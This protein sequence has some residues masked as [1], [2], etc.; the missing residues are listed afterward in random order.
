MSIRRY[1]LH[2]AYSE[3]PSLHTG[4]QQQGNTAHLGRP[5]VDRLAALRFPIPTWAVS[6][7]GSFSSSHTQVSRIPSCGRALVTVTHQ[8]TNHQQIKLESRSYPILPWIRQNCR[9]AAGQKDAASILPLPTF[10]CAAVVYGYLSRIPP[11]HRI[12]T[13]LEP[14]SPFGPWLENVSIGTLI[15]DHLGERPPPESPLR[16]GLYLRLYP[17]ATRPS[18][19]QTQ[20]RSTTARLSPLRF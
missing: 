3:C 7:K 1:Y 16:S 18:I 9:A 4:S 20:R 11:L 8:P 2:T 13:W 15:V 12:P 14:H 5:T 17:P 6:T 10:T 19:S